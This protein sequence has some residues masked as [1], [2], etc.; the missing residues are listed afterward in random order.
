MFDHFSQNPPAPS[1]PPPPQKVIRF[2][3]SYFKTL[4]GLLK[5]AALVCNFVGFIC[6]KVSFSWVSSIFYNILYWSGN[7]LTTFL[8]LMY[9]F[10]FVEK[11]D[12]W[13]WLKLE[14]FYCAIM[15]LGY[16][17]TTIFAATIGDSAGYAVTFFGVCAIG[18]YG[19][20]CYL[21]YK[22][23]KRGLPPQ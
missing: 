21:K 10:H 1:E 20:D 16:I 6:I 13:P 12:R 11:Y 17:A 2:D 3:K 18:V 7:I 4:P 19:L 23:W 8:L 9:V 14:F 22:A 15:T 5:I